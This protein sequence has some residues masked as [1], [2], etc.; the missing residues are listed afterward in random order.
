MRRSLPELAIVLGLIGCGDDGAGT[1]TG[2]TDTTTDTT[3][4]ESDT[5]D[6]PELAACQALPA[7]ALA[8]WVTG[9]NLAPT[10]ESTEARIAAAGAPTWALALD[11]VRVIDPAEAPSLA[12]SPASMTFALGLGYAR[13]QGSECGDEIHARMRF[14]ELGDPVHQ[15]LGASIREL[16]GL[17]LPV[18]QDGEDRVDVSFRPSVWSLE[19]PPMGAPLY[20]AKTHQVTKGSA[21]Q[22]AAIREVMN[23]VIEAESSGLLPNFVPSDHPKEDTVAY[24]VN[25]SYLQAPWRVGLSGRGALPFTRDGG[26]LVDAVGIGSTSVPA[27]YYDS[28]TFDALTLQLRG[29]RLAITFITPDLGVYTDLA[30]FTQALTPAELELA[31]T[32]AA[33]SDVDLTMPIVKIQSQTIDYYDPLGFM[34]PLFTLRSVLHGATVEIDEKGIKAAAATAGEEWSTGTGPPPPD[35]VV[36][37]DRPFLFFVYDTTTSYVL[38]SGRYAGP[39]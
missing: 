20:G 6:D 14:P 29:G 13:W 4:G 24:Y 2:T 10:G 22:L 23:C 18:G 30:A 3:H 12:A 8:E 37:L 21:A 27:T 33:H 17:S 7:A 15:T 36:V 28:P 35:R 26:E 11:L 31:R 25:A 38:Y 9:P 39:S 19:G 5:S 34:C 1:A 16:E 32:G